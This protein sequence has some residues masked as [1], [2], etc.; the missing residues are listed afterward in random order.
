MAVAGRLGVDVATGFVWEILLTNHPWRICHHISHPR[1]LPC[2]WAVRT[3]FPKR[4]DN[5]QRWGLTRRPCPC[6]GFHPLPAANGTPVLALG[7]HWPSAGHRRGMYPV[8]VQGILQIPVAGS[9]NDGAIVSLLRLLRGGRCG[10]A[11]S[12][13]SCVS[14][15]R[16][17]Q[18]REESHGRPI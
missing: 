7:T 8:L 18:Y 14:C 16:A 3:G 13:G 15:C 1:N 5:T 4:T 9:V 10:R 11:V 6:R 12:E 17:D 2:A